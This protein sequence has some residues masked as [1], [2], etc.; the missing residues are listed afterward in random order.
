MQSTLLGL[1][2][3]DSENIY[4]VRN[5]LFDFIGMDEDFTKEQKVLKR[6]ELKNNYKLLIPFGYMEIYWTG[7]NKDDYDLVFKYHDVRKDQWYITSV[8]ITNTILISR[9]TNQMVY[10]DIDEMMPTDDNR[11]YTKFAFYIDDNIES[12]LELIPAQIKRDLNLL[13]KAYFRDTFEEYLASFLQSIDQINGIMPYELEIERYYSRDVV[14]L[15]QECL[16]DLQMIISYRL[17]KTYC[18]EYWYDVNF[19]E[20]RNNYELIR[21]VKTKKLFVFKYL[22][23]DFIFEASQIDQAFTEEELETIFAH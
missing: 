13:S 10:D 20:I 18:A 9:S 17:L 22:K 1:K 15:T 14:L 5:E 19:K 3:Y 8:D 6:K 7:K 16:E 23:G 21:D 12:V 11:L 4:R 2:Y